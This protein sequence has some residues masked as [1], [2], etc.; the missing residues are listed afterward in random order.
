MGWK[1]IDQVLAM[2]EPEALGD[3]LARMRQH[4]DELEEAFSAE[5]ERFT[6]ARVDRAARKRGQAFVERLRR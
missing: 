5:Q 4:L 2:R 6:R 1:T 3:V